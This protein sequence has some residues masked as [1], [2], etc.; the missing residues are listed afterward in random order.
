[1]FRH[2]V[3]VTVGSL[4]SSNSGCVDTVWARGHKTKTITG[5]TLCWASIQHL[6]PPQAISKYINT[7]NCTHMGYFRYVCN[8]NTQ[9][10][11]M[12]RAQK[13]FNARR[14][15]ENKCFLTFVVVWGDCIYSWG[16]ELM[17]LIS[18]APKRRTETRTAPETGGFQ[19]FSSRT[20]PA[21][22]SDIGESNY[23]HSDG[24]GTS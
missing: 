8:P 17:C 16:R 15:E 21:D 13:A 2:S 10:Y 20:Q 6:N 14:Q 18:P 19:G 1:M 5:T 7:L 4:N 11:Q 3:C 9:K 23:T 24:A 12:Q 22:L